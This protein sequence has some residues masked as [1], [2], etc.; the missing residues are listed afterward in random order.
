MKWARKIGS[1]F[2]G[3]IAATIALAFIAGVLKNV[4]KPGSSQDFRSDSIPI[5]STTEWN[6]YGRYTSTHQRLWKDFKDRDHSLTYTVDYSQDRGSLDYK[7]REMEPYLD[8]RQFWG[9]LYHF[10]HTQEQ[11]KL[12]FLYTKIDSARK[13]NKFNYKELAEYLVSFVQDIPYVLVIGSDCSNVGDPKLQDEVN[14]GIMPCVGNVP[15]G[16]HG[17]RKF[18]STLEGDCDT[19]SVLLFALLDHYN[20]ATCILV[21][22]QYRHAV[23]GVKMRGYGMEKFFRGRT[24]KFW[25][26]TAYGFQVGEMA[27][28]MRNIDFW[29]VVLYNEI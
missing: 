24:F 8:A 18:L 22:K 28:H 25:E 9:S 10:L 12:A 23:I 19:R 2:I 27:A 6:V 26:T 11:D 13:V 17:P 3:I 1:F 14:R 21:S 20:Y 5:S 4:E 16:I 7:K 15:F 29:N